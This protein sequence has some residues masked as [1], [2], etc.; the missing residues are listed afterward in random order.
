[1]VRVAYRVKCLECGWL[2]VPAGREPD[3]F[4]DKHVRETKHPTYV[5]G[6]PDNTVSEDTQR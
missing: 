4:A 6:E 5:V 1:M 3:R 2:Q